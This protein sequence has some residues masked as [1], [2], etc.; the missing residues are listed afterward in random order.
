MGQLTD[1]SKLRVQ[2][3]LRGKRNES[4]EFSLGMKQTRERLDLSASLSVT[5]G[6]WPYRRA[7]INCDNLTADLASYL[8]GHVGDL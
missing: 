1:D 8:N 4:G 6:Q 7:S 2:G 5:R 3:L